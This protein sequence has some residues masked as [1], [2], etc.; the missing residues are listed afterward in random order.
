MKPDPWQA[1]GPI[2]TWTVM[3]I[4]ARKSTTRP[5]FY[6]IKYTDEYVY[7]NVNYVHEKYIVN[8]NNTRS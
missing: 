6:K 5:G 7:Y 3:L 4:Q 8:L 1:Q 2:K